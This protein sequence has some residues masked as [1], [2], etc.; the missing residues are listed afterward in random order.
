MRLATTILPVLLLI[1]S[2]APAAVIQYGDKDLLGTG[3]YVVDP[4]MG[5]TLEGLAP[6]VSTVGALGLGG[7]FHAF[8]FVPGIGDYPGT[9]Q[10]YVGSSQIGFSDGYSA[11][12]GRLNGPQVI[13]MDYSSL[14]PPGSVITSLTLGIGFDDGRVHHQ[15]FCVR[16]RLE[17]GEQVIQNTS[18]HQIR[19]NQAPS[20]LKS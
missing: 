5:A 6:G 3:T 12:G 13:T 8:P 4:T 18:F 9:D 17:A 15:P 16:V 7:Q 2:S 14:V 20:K 1:A 10:I 11:F 19:R